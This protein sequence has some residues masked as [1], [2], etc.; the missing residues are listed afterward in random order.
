MQKSRDF[1]N[2]NFE[3]QVNEVPYQ[4]HISQ[5]NHR[6]RRAKIDDF[7]LSEGIVSHEDLPR[8]GGRHLT[9]A[10]WEMIKDN[11]G[12]YWLVVYSNGLVDDI[13]QEK[14]GNFIK[15]SNK[16]EY[17]LFLHNQNVWFAVHRHVTHEIFDDYVRR[18]YRAF[19]TLKKMVF[20][21][22]L[23][24]YSWGQEV[25]DKYHNKTHTYSGN[26]NQLHADFIH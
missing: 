25:I 18:R 23:A 10:Q 3:S 21:D 1:S 9:N 13:Y 16:D 4:S 11:P 2:N 12:D 5:E 26:S 19:A 14:L 15:A 24:P 17:Q 8:I 20:P 22:E 7:L 6:E